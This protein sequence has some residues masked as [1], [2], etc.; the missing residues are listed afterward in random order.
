MCSIFNYP[1]NIV[2]QN[3][4]KNKYR[5]KEVSVRLH[6]HKAKK[7]YNKQCHPNPR[8]KKFAFFHLG[9]LCRY[10]GT[11]SFFNNFW[12]SAGDSNKEIYTRRDATKRNDIRKYSMY[13][14]HSNGKGNIC[15]YHRS[16]NKTRKIT[17]FLKNTLNK[18]SNACW[19]HDCNK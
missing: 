11:L 1:R 7:A 3:V 13:R 2:K 12:H 4:R 10:T 14:N 8:D 19:I 5:P 9:I 15:K 17:L 6:W 16:N 18:C